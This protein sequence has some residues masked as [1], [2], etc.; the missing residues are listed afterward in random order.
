MSEAD[1]ARAMELR[2]HLGGRRVLR[3][4]DVHDSKRGLYGLRAITL[5]S[6]DSTGADYLV[7]PG[8]GMP[9]VLARRRR[10][11]E[12]AL[13][14]HTGAPFFLEL[15]DPCARPRKDQLA[16]EEWFRFVKGG[17]RT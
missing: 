4:S 6:I 9:V 16:Q 17:N 7:M 15:K 11:V 13:V 8:K 5:P 12:E 14:A 2:L 1:F 10:D 3:V